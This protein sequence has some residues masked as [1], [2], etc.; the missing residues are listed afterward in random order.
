MTQFNPNCD[1]IDSKIIE[2][3]NGTM[4]NDGTVI[5]LSQL[6]TVINHTMNYMKFTIRYN[7]KIRNLRTYLQKQHRSISKFIKQNTKYKLTAQEGSIY[8]MS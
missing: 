2:I 1:I 6:Y 7:N 5:E 8:I 3:I 4:F